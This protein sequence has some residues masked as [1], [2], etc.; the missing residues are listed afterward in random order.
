MCDPATIAGIALSVGSTVAHQAAAG[1]VERA[2][3]D[4]IG[5]ERQIQ[6]QFDNQTFDL[7][8]TAQDRYTTF[9]ADMGAKEQQLGDYLAQQTLAEPTGN[10]ALPSSTSNIA[11]REEASQRADARQRT[12]ENAANLARLRSFGDLLGEFGRSDA[13]DA[14]S[15]AQIGGF[16]MGSSN[17]LPY[18]LEHAQSAGDGMSMFGNILGVGGQ[19]MTS[20]GLGGGGMGGSALSGLFGPADVTAKTSR[21][22][23]NAA[24]I[25]GKSQMRLPSLYGG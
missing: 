20:A 1:Q 19:A 11:V 23:P 10:A 5:V 6:K 14:G 15:I 25:A 3:N 2:R 21:Y 13:R 4:A 17:I 8:D 22:M 9:G 24:A 12:D 16:K 7:N 18:E